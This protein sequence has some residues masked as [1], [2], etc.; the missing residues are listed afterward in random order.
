MRV[1]VVAFGVTL[2]SVCRSA[3]AAGADPAAVPEVDEVVE[4]EPA[5]SSGAGFR[6]EAP[7]KLGFG[8]ESYAGIAAVFTSGEDRAHALAGALA[9]LRLH[10][11]QVGGTFEITDSGE[12]KTLGEYQIEHWRAFGGFLGVFVPY[13]HWVTFDATLGIGARTYVN[14][15]TIYG[16]HGLSTSLTALT[17][18]LGVSD[19]M[20]HKLVAPRL[21][22]ALVL[23]ADLSRADVGWH[24]RYVAAD[25]TVSESS[26]T[27]PIGGVSIALVVTAGF[28]LGG[29][30]R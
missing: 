10:Y 29:R 8:L 30:P 26:G 21:G 25:G 18:R 22:G 2:L 20:T 24:R 23:S 11:F 4:E 3:V 15:M 27:T 16:D 1:W 13:E 19:R 17:L 6:L 5:P 28:E 9:R 12:A 14:S 7:S